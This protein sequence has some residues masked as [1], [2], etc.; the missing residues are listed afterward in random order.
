ML[1]ILAGECL[2]PA[3]AGHGDRGRDGGL[4]IRVAVEEGPGHSCPA[5]D[6][7]DADLGLL[8]AEPGDRVVGALEGGLGCAGSSSRSAAR[9][10]WRIQGRKP[11]PAAGRLPGRSGQSGM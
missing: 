6:G 3:L 2:D 8:A 11:G 7:D 4:G 9:Q 1:V 10:G 5:R